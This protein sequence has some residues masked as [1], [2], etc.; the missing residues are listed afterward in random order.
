MAGIRL[1]AG[2]GWRVVRAYFVR[3]RKTH[4]TAPILKNGLDVR[5]AE[6]DPK[7]PGRRAFAVALGL[8]VDAAKDDAQRNPRLSPSTHQ[9]ESRADDPYEMAGIDA[10]EV[11]LHTTAVLADVNLR[12]LAGPVSPGQIV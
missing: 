1:G 3:R 2:V 5:L 10:R 9:R 4:G 7:R 11:L 6:L 12:R 8:H